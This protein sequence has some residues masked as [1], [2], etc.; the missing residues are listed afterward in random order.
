LN[1]EGGS[2]HQECSTHKSRGRRHRNGGKK[3]AETRRVNRN[4]RVRNSAGREAKKRKRGA[5]GEESKRG[6]RG[7]GLILNLGRSKKKK[8]IVDISKIQRS[9]L[10]KRANKTKKRRKN[11]ERCRGGVNDLV[12]GWEVL[13]RSQILQNTSPLPKEC[14]QKVG[15]TRTKT[16]KKK[17]NEGRTRKEGD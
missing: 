7:E 17:T 5:G 3:D 2:E 1:K 16:Q 14:Q 12:S 9:L 10:A 4:P 15:V 6:G 8:S 11:R 13:D